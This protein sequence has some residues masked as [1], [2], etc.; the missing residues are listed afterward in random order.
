MIVYTTILTGT[1]HLFQWVRIEDQHLRFMLFENR[2]RGTSKP[3]SG[4]IVW[5]L[6]SER[7]SLSRACRRSQRLVGLIFLFYY[8]RYFLFGKFVYVVKF[9]SCL[10]TPHSSGGIG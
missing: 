3:A 7:P 1:G 10:L 5:L 8:F 6:D 9:S 2:Q 4:N